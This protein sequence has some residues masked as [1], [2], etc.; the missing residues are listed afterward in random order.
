MQA[1]ILRI[2][3]RLL[4]EWLNRRRHIA[5][6]Y[7]KEINNP[8]VDLPHRH[9]GR[10][11]SYHQYVIRCRQRDKVISALK[12]RSIG[13]GIHYPVPVHMMPAYKDLAGDLPLTVTEKACKEILSLPIHEGLSN[14]EAEKVAEAINCTA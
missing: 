6:I 13:F 11:P 8:L 4:P 10:N 1:A 7:N 12:S 2:K 3:L 14:K 9:S 5:A